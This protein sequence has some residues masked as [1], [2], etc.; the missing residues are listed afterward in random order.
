MKTYALDTNCFIDAVNPRSQSYEVMQRIFT[1]FNGGKLSL[2]VSL[3]TLHELEQ[4]KDS[5]WE[6][7]KTLAE[8]PHWPIGTWDE[9]VGTWEEQTGTWDDAKRNDKIQLELK[10]LAKSGTDIR[11]RGGYIDALCS[12][13]DGFVTSDKQLVGAGPY[14][15]IN[16]RFFTK[17]LTPEQLADELDV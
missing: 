14:K 2:K 10:E 3:Q 5:A 15:R 11:D 4:K 12:E 13:L 7:A 1:A 6:L 8:L 17:V 16:E 9:Q